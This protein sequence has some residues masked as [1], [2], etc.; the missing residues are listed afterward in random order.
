MTGPQGRLFGTN[1]VRFIP[2]VSADLEFV[3]KLAECIG[4]YFSDGEILVGRDGRLSGEAISLALTSGLMSSGRGVAEAGLVPTPALQYAVKALGYRGGVMVTASHNPAE[5]NGLKVMGPD[6][7]EIN[8]L[9]EQRLEKVFRDGSLK[10]ADWKDVGT[11]RSEPSVVRTYLNGVLSKVE[12]GPISGRKFSVVVDPGNGAQCLAAPYLLDMLGCKVTTIN[13]II[14]GRFPGRGPEPTPDTLGDLGSAVRAVGADLGVAYDGDGDRAI[15][16]DENGTVYWGDQSCS[17]IADYILEGN[18]DAT[19]VTPISSSQVVEAIAAKRKARVIRTRVGS[20]DVSRTII[21]RGAFF[22]FEENGGCIYPTH[23]AVRDGGMATALML[24]CLA[25]RGLSF[26]KIM[27]NTLPKFFQAKTKISVAP[28]KV[29]EVMKAVEKQGGQRVE[30]VDGLKIWTDDKTWVLV[31]PSGTE[32]MIRIFAESDTEEK[33]GSVSR[34]F[35]R[36]VKS[37]SAS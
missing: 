28:E 26:S 13:S 23:I 12:T 27:A 8:R 7:V 11:A 2:G 5:Y 36:L 10:R 25:A 15:F 3:I 30:R 1:G 19:I 17:L 9:D 33:L 31:R 34:K 20:V 21:D 24:E 32:P 22:G 14:D 35:V 4:T 37:A 6:G 16:C 18:P 29:K